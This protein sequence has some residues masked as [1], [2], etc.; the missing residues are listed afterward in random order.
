MKY[1]IHYHR[2]GELNGY[3]WIETV[4]GNNA[5]GIAKLDAGICNPWHTC[6]DGLNRPSIGVGNDKLYLSFR[7]K[8][9][10]ETNKYAK[11][12]MLEIHWPYSDPEPVCGWRAL[13]LLQG[14]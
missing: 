13:E 12:L 10:S 14:F 1:T 6:S 8:K 9:V 4:D 5:P 3:L 7:A 2:S 11:I